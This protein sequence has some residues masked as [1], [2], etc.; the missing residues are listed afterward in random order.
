MSILRFLALIPL[1]VV[2]CDQGLTIAPVSGVITWEGRPLRGASIT[3]QPIAQAGSQNPGP[4]SFGQTDEQG[5]FQLE[6]VK[7]ALKGAIIGEHRV[8]I[9]RAAEIDP[10]N[11][12]RRSADGAEYWTDDP[13][14]N[15][16]P[17]GNMWPARFTDGSLRLQVPPE[18]TDQADFRLTAKP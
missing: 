13:N 18:G 2:G 16:Q 8:M 12:P 9:S 4:G 7:P 17:A 1:L 10:T 15:R 6:L 14:S 11:Q 5:R 3:T